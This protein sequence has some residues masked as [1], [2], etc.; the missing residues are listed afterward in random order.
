MLSPSEIKKLLN[1]KEVILADRQLMALAETWDL[2]H[3]EISAQLVA[4][5]YSYMKSRYQQGE[6]L[7]DMEKGLGIAKESVSRAIKELEAHG[8]LTVSRGTKPFRYAVIK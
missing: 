3:I 1:K 4:T 2:S 8:Y 5:V 6:T 7:E